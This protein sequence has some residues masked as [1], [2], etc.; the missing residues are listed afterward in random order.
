[1]HPGHPREMTSEDHVITAG[2][3]GSGMFLL[4]PHPKWNVGLSQP[5][6]ESYN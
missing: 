4:C 3:K 2:L 5:H 1:M 6:Q